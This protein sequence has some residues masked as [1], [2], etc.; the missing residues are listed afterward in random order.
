MIMASLC[1]LDGNGSARAKFPALCKESI[2]NLG[3][4]AK[5]YCE[6][7]KGSTKTRAGL[8]S[9]RVVENIPIHQGGKA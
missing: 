8:L 6:A 4:L 5:N 3:I 1:H 2:M 9:K 7:K